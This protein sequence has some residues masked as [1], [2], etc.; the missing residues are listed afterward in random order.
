[1]ECAD[2]L[3]SCPPHFV[4]FAWRYHTCVVICL[5]RQA[6]TRA[7]GP[8]VFLAGFPIPTPYRC[9]DNRVSQIP[10][11]PLCTCPAP[12]GPRWDQ[13]RQASFGMLMLPSVNTTT[14]APTITLSRLNHTACTLAV[15]ASQHG[16]PRDHARL[17]S[18]CWPAL[19]GGIGYP[20]GS[21]ERF[22]SFITSSFPRL[23][24]AQSTRALGWRSSAGPSLP[25]LPS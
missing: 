8:G 18:G 16:S 13:T 9:G 15:Y 17:A 24:L 20:Q 21:T 6:T 4:S 1:M 19:P 10:E 22:Q 5:S 7:W 14:S 23:L 12:F 11:E 2:S 25:F 3:L